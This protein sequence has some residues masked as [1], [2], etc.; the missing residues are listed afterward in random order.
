MAQGPRCFSQQKRDGSALI[1]GR[2][3]ALVRTSDLV[4][5][6]VYLLLNLVLRAAQLL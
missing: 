2:H 3:S 1:S 4:C 6:A 5:D